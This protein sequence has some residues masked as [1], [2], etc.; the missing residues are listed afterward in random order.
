MGGICKRRE[1]K[2]WIDVLSWAKKVEEL[3]AGE[4]CL[5]QWM[6]MARR[7]DMI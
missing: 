7:M 6:V 2:Y 1:R 3:G 5:L 4:I